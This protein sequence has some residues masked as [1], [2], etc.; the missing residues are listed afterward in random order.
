MAG[1]PANACMGP[2][3]APVGRMAVQPITAC[4]QHP[5][6]LPGRV[7]WPWKRSL[8]CRPAAQ[9]SRQV[10]AAESWAVQLWQGSPRG[11]QV[12]PTASATADS[13]APAV[14]GRVSR[15]Q[16]GLPLCKADGR[17][18][19]S[20]SPGVSHLRCST[21]VFCRDAPGCWHIARRLLTPT[22]NWPAVCLDVFGGS[23]GIDVIQ[24]STGEGGL[25]PRLEMGV[26]PTATKERH[27]RVTLLSDFALP[28]RRQRMCS[29]IH[30][31]MQHKGGGR[32]VRVGLLRLTLCWVMLGWGDVAV[33]AH[34]VDAQGCGPGSLSVDACIARVLPRLPLVLRALLKLTRK[35]L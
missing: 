16:T 8:Q 19:S 1:T 9:G 30:K 24:C 25:W 17:G 12:G 15:L 7:D 20:R 21:H 32:A 34:T 6:T 13:L 28:R 29:A 2:P 26:C 27:Q 4:P 3:R 11:L 10:C 18:N 22:A 5:A 35:P 33:E 31:K 14:V 23:R